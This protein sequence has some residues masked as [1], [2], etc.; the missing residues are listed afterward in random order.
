MSDKELSAGKPYPIQSPTR[1]DWSPLWRKEDWLAVW[2]GFLILGLAATRSVTWLPKIG[3]WTDSPVS[4]VKIGDLP[5]FVLLGFSL[6]L[7][8]S[9]AL[10]SMREKTREYWAGFPL[11]F[12]L[13][14]LSLLLSNQKSIN[15]WGLEYVLWALLF[16]LLISNVVGVP[17]WLK[18]AV[19]T[20]LFIKVGLVLVGAEILFQVVLSAG[21]FGVFEVTVGLLL[22]WYLCYFLATRLGLSKSF[23]CILS[24]A[25]SICGVSAAIAAGGAVKG[26]PK[27]VSYT[28]S[29]VLLFAMPMLIVMPTLGR[30]LG[31]PDAV[32]GAWIGG[33]I[34]TTPAVVAAGA[35]Y[36]NKAMQVA[37]ILKMSQNVMIGVA[38]FLLALYWVLRVEKRPEERPRPIEIWYRFPKFV[39]GFI[40]ASMIFSFL[41]FPTLG[42]K[43]VD[44][45]LGVTKGLRGWFFAMAFVSIGL[46][47]RFT[48]L[49]KTGRGRP[50]VVFLAA[51]LW[52]MAISL[53]SAYLFFG[54][55]FFPPPA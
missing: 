14:F 50:F 39:L 20:E 44:A 12:I 35:L 54:G 55:T 51:T 42:G 49:L 27:E 18:P 38:A 1:L 36:S 9:V 11:V 2:V 40:I 41:L 23:A 19:R 32:V 48:E 17:K 43:S 13:S 46:D 10:R 45:I 21:A 37:S 24:S 31:L 15:Q 8:T 5:Y 6:L 33:T 47:T 34:D 4:A 16:G 22:V 53:L 26:D 7:L 29:L 52:D 3:P 30:A 28:I 25:T